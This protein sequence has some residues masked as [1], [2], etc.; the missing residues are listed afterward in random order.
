[1]R[2]RAR[3]LE[4]LESIYRESYDR[5]RSDG[6]ETRM[7][8]LDNAYTR[9]QLMLEILLDIRELLAVGPAAAGTAMGS[10]IP[11]K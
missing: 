8:E 9:D 10:Q 11:P 6:L 7:L 3:I 4:N 1:M 2:T 5:A